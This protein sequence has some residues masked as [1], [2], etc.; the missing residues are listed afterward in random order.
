MG[1]VK[2]VILG[3]V[4]VLKMNLFG[5]CYSI[6]MKQAKTALPIPEAVDKQK[7]D[8]LLRRMVEHKPVPRSEVRVQRKRKVKRIIEK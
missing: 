3:I 8:D 4:W 2:R 6:P 7:F 1:A 5:L